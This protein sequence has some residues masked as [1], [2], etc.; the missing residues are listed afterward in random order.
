[1]NQ[2]Q[3]NMTHLWFVLNIFEYKKNSLKNVLIWKFDSVFIEMFCLFLVWSEKKVLWELLIFI[4]GKLF[5]ENLIIY[6][7]LFKLW[8]KAP[9]L[10]L[11]VN[12]MNSHHPV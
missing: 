10:L 4:P 11:L 3:L 9:V 1:M 7:K 8:L 5:F 6:S 12:S 2:F